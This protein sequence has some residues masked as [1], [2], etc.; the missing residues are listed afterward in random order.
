VRTR[1]R[2]V[3]RRRGCLGGAARIA[4]AAAAALAIAVLALWGAHRWSAQR[5]PSPP[6]VDEAVRAKPAIDY[7]C[8]PDPGVEAPVP[9]RDG[10]TPVRAP[11]GESAGVPQAGPAVPLEPP[12]PRPLP[13]PP[14]PAPATPLADDLAELRRRRLLVP[15]AGVGRDELRDSFE[16]RRGAGRRHSAIDILAPRGTPVVAVEEGTIARL[17]ES[18]LGGVTI[19]QFGPS[20]R[21]SYYYAHLDRYARGL[22]EGAA[23]R[24]GQ[25]IGY[26]GTTGNAPESAPHLHFAIYRLTPEQGWW[27]G[28][29]INPYPA[30]VPP[31]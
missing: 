31:L 2:V 29:P 26:V 3:E 13:L 17:F 1:E 14:P 15:V 11:S 18:R 8:C 19:Y 12:P 25:V 20:G 21:F 30:L 27:Q 7:F 16:E 22:E 28:E 5:R 4:A 10:A 9:G 6:R 23:V 24:R